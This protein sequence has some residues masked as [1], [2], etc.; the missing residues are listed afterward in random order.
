MLEKFKKNLISSNEMKQ[1]KGGLVAPI[2]WDCVKENGGRILITG[3]GAASIS[4]AIDDYND[5]HSADIVGCTIL[6]MD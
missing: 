3:Y 4:G 5:T 1:V 2:T 6:E